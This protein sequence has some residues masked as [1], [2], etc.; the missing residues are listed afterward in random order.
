MSSSEHR[1]AKAAAVK[2]ETWEND[3]SILAKPTGWLYH[4]ST[5]FPHRGKYPVAYFLEDILM[6][7][8]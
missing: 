8:P 5:A 7:Y 1:L 3:P 6:M 4:S 2:L